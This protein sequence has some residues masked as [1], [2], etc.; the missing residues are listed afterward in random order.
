MPSGGTRVQEYDYFSCRR[1]S[2]DAF[3]W[4]EFTNLYVHERGDDGSTTKRKRG[5]G[6]TMATTTT[7]IGR[8][9]DG[10]SGGT[11]RGYRAR[12]KLMWQPRCLWRSG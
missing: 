10:T 11:G 9:D 7:H 3:R 6:T 1:S 2:D 4:P 5:N 12:V 8:D